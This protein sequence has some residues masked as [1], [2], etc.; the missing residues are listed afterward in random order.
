MGARVCREYLKFL[1]K[2]FQKQIAYLDSLQKN[3]QI[4]KKNQSNWS[5]DEGDIVDLKSALFDRKFCDSGTIAMC[6]SQESTC[7]EVQ[8]AC[9]DFRRKAEVID[10]VV[11]REPLNMQREKQSQKVVEKPQLEK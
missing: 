11:E 10:F 5:S 7:T 3:T 9:K 8:D 2:Y 1:V 4:E 6:T